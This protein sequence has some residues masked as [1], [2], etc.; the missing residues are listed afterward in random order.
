MIVLTIVVDGIG[1]DPSGSMATFHFPCLLCLQE[2]NYLLQWAIDNSSPTLIASLRCLC[3]NSSFKLIV[4]T[5]TG[6]IASSR[7][8]WTTSPCTD[9]LPNHRCQLQNGTIDAINHLHIIN[10]MGLT[11]C[12]SVGLVDYDGLPHPHRCSV[13]NEA[14][15][16]HSSLLHCIVG[17]TPSS[18]GSR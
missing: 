16:Q 15:C 14:L 4:G 5:L 1:L 7:W 10:V 9:C 8:R 12:S 2:E 18:G 17:C 6:S 13:S 11:N 3:S